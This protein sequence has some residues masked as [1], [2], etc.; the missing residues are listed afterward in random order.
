[1][2]SSDRKKH[3]PLHVEELRGIWQTD[4][5]PNVRRLLWEIARLRDVVLRSQRGLEMFNECFPPGKYR[6]VTQRIIDTLLDELADE[7]VV[8]EDRWPRKYSG[9]KSFAPPRPQVRKK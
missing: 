9:S 2:A 6:N 3:P 8:Q 7:P 5:S 1:M 4:R